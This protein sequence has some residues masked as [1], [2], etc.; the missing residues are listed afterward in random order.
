[1]DESPLTGE[2]VPVD[3]HADPLAHDVVLADRKN[4][5]LCRHLR[6]LRHGGGPRVGHGRSNRDRPHRLAHRRRGGALHTADEKITR[7]QQAAAVD[8]PRPLGATFLVGVL[9]GEKPVEMFMAA[10]A[11]AVGAIPEGLPAA[12]TIV[13]AIGVSAAWH[14]A[15][16]HP[17]AARRGD[18][19]QHHRHLLGQ[20]GH[21]HREPDDRAA[22]DHRRHVIYE[23]TGSGYEAQASCGS[24][25]ESRNRSSIPRCWSASAPVCSAMIPAS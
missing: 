10:V 11:L 3:K 2:S 9:R 14:G 17:Q 15:G 7:F 25:A 12:V 23:I 13:L 21:A 16:H 8:H 4:L 5:G 18:A 24:T 19:R 20:N 22:R 1:V 6:H